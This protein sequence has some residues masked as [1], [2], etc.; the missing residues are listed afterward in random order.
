MSSKRRPD[1]REGDGREQAPEQELGT[2]ERSADMAAQA[3]AQRP[4]AGP[5]A[6]PALTN[7]DATP[8]AGLLPDLEEPSTTPESTGG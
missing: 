7:K 4:A 3:T 2:L 6:K 1:V 8:D 5:H